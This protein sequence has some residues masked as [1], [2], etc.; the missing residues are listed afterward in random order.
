MQVEAITVE[1]SP[2]A[3]PDVAGL[4]RSSGPSSLS[5]EQVWREQATVDK[6]STKYA[7]IKASCWTD[8][9]TIVRRERSIVPNDQYVVAIAL[10]PVRMTLGTINNTI[11]EGTMPTGMVH[12]SEPGQAVEAEFASPCEFI[13]FHVAVGYVRDRRGAAGLQRSDGVPTGE[14]RI[15]DLL[16]RDNLA[17]Q[18]SRALTDEFNGGDPF[19]AASVGQTILMR[20][21]AARAQTSRVGALPKWRLRRVSILSLTLPSRLRW[22]TLLKRQV[23]PE[24]ILQPSSGRPQGAVHMTIC[25]S[26]GSN[27][28]SICLP[29]RTRRSLRSRSASAS[30]PNRTFRPS[31][32]ASLGTPPRA[33]SGA[34][35]PGRDTKGIGRI[36]LRLECVGRGA[37]A[38]GPATR[39]VMHMTL[40]VS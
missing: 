20:A 5:R 16:V 14:R 11:F 35:A 37:N 21:L 38:R 24:C 40:P 36:S 3:W 17:A 15:R 13:H 22:L 29:V 34:D 27:M 28:L 10:R 7:G 12:V 2:S 18:L 32:S 9:R 23:C 39:R 26:I 25:C 8:E 1:S 33:G 4:R 31:S 30:R 6:S 19:Y